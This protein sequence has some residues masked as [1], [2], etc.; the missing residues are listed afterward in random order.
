MSKSDEL[1]AKEWL[2]VFSVI[3]FTPA[4]LGHLVSYGPTK[5]WTSS[6]WKTEIVRCG[7]GTWETTPTGEVWFKW[8]EEEEVK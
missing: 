2:G 1:T 8:K 5:Y 4:F 6:Y 7:Y 3:A